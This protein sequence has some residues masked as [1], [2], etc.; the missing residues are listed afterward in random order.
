MS[1]T[2]RALLPDA[3]FNDV[4]ATAL[5]NNP[6]TEPDFASR[7]LADALG[8]VATAAASPIR[9]ERSRRGS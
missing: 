6:G 2:A 1:R 3:Q 4:R 8:F 7:V 9:A 5:D